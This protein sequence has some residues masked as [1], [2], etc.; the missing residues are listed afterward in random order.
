MKESVPDYLKVKHTAESWTREA[1]EYIKDQM[2]SSSFAI[3]TKANQHD[4]VTDVDK[5]VEAFF[6]DKIR[7]KYPE[8][9]LMGEEGS[10]EKI[11]DLNGIVWI[12]DPIDGTINFVHQSSHFAISIG[13]YEDGHPVVGIVYDV[14]NG[15]MYSS[16]KGEG[17]TFNGEKIS[18]I[19]NNPLNESIISF[20]SGWM[21]QDRRLERLVKEVRGVRSYG[22]AAL[23]IAYVAVGKLDA[24]I[25]F[26]LA[27]WDIAGGYAILN[28]VGGKATNYEGK[29]LNLLTKD[30]LIAASPSVHSA[31]FEKITK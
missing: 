12:L 26:N 28:E 22:V 15:D 14:M 24:Y 9:R 20:N 27:P 16:L 30:T 29:P 10:F 8:H 17:A 5:N 18:P 25:S 23:E 1:G 2:A 19:I 13:I 3:S 4:L 7:E 31:I 21:L 6:F 11:K